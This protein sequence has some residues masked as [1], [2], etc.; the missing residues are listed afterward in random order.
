MS[1][2]KGREAIAEAMIQRQLEALE[3]LEGPY[4]KA[5]GKLAMR[6]SLL[7]VVLERFSWEAWN[8]SPSSGSVLT[9]DLRVTHLVEKLEASAKDLIPNI[10]DRKKLLSI[11]K[12]IKRV[13][14]KRNDFLHS[15]WIIR[16]GEPVWCFSRTRGALVGPDAPSAKQ[17][18]ELCSAI[19]KV[20][21]DFD[22]FK[23]NNPLMVKGLL[24][25]G[26]KADV[27]TDK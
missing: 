24:G 9:K 7:H 22:R 6:F 23:E 27:N 4:E 18:N 21:T 5:L 2:D 8:L 25:L 1:K 14:K 13:A 16:E 19:I 11:L 12:E 15:L 26:L 20:L 10:D 17:I 3:R